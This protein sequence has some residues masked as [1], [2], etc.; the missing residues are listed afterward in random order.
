MRLL[1]IGGARQEKSKRLI[2]VACLVTLVT[3]KLRSLG[4]F[5][6][7]RQSVH[8]NLCDLR[9]RSHLEWYRW[10]LGG[11]QGNRECH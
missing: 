8:T 1:D 10:R 7:L 6:A 9:P 4:N 2:I 3:Q 11:A 5:E